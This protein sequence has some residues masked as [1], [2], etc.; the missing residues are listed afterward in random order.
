ME[1]SR[2][3][4]Q[5]AKKIKHLSSKISDVK[6]VFMP[7]LFFEDAGASNKKY[8]QILIVERNNFILGIQRR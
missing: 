1:R 8:L 5:Q 2:C 6:T 4:L 7:Y 3:H